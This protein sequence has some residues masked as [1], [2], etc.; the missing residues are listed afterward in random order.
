MIY[1]HYRDTEA[2]KSNKSPK[3]SLIL[4]LPHT[5]SFTYLTGATGH[6]SYTAGIAHQP[7]LFEREWKAEVFTISQRKMSM[8]SYVLGLLYRFNSSSVIGS[9]QSWFFIYHAQHG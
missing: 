8:A 2:V 1:H 6:K 3:L 7:L 5:M 4:K 9:P